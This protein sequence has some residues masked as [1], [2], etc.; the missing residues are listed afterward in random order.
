MNL[1]ERILKTGNDNITLT[2]ITT[3]GENDIPT[4]VPIEND[5]KNKIGFAS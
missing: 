4:V 5:K 3:I 2:S 1:A